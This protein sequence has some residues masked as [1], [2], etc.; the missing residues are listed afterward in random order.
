M[1]GG[2]KLC[3]VLYISVQRIFKIVIILLLSCPDFQQAVQLINAFRKTVQFFNAGSQTWIQPR[4]LEQLGKTWTGTTQW[5]NHGQTT[6]NQR[7]FNVYNVYTTLFRLTMMFP[8]GRLTRKET[9][10][11]HNSQ[12]YRLH[13]SY[14]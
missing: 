14:F 5:A 4:I 1:Y 7:C 11:R 12:I 13:S 8:L 6:F 10:F 9:V 3:I 2:L